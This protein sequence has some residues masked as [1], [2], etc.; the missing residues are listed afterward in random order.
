[1][2]FRPPALC[3]ILALSGLA[4]PALA[5]DVFTDGV[6]ISDANPTS[7]D[8]YVGDDSVLR[9]H[10][11]IGEVCNLAESFDVGYIL[12]LNTSSPSIF[13][14]DDSGFSGSTP[15]NDW[16]IRINDPEPFTEGGLNRFSIEDIT[17]ATIPFTI[18]AGAPENAFW[19]TSAGNIG[20]GTLLPQDRIHAVGTFGPSV[21]F[22]QTGN[23]LVPAQTWRLIGQSSFNIADT[24]AG[25]TPFRLERAAP[26]NALYIADTGNVG[27]GTAT[28][29]APFEVSDDATFSYFRITAEQAAVNQSVDITFTGG[30]LGTGE[31]RYNVV[32]GDGPEMKLNA[33]GDMEIDGTLTTGGPTCASGCDAVF[34]SNFKRLSVAEHAA[35]MWKNGHLPAVGT[36][37]PGAPMNV[38]EKIGGILNELEHAHIYI[39][40][41]EARDRAREAE[42]AR[43]GDRVARLEAMLAQVDGMLDHPVS[44]P[45]D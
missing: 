43:L 40:E 8:L 39:A 4:A 18:A 26:T 2:P 12:K 7:A 13:F 25:T 19:M 29:D 45:T 3:A 27:F 34:D 44:P 42:N 35:L 24:T 11:C 10:T 28:P 31:L 9:G 16:R 5:Q 38:A 30:P 33:D 1:M 17:A 37:R 20:L 22:E 14:D 36:T 32:D 41:L 15:S 23:G 6:R 21:R